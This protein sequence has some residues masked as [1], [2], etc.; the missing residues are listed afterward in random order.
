MPLLRYGSPEQKQ[1]Y[2]P[3]LADGS[4][5]GA[6]AGTEPEAGSDIFAMS[7]TATKREGGYVLDGK[8]IFVTNGPIA[9][10]LIVYAT[11]DRSLG[12]TGVTAFLVERGTEGMRVGP[13]MESMGLRAAPMAEISFDDCFIP[14]SHRLGREGRG[15]QVFAYAMEWE[16]G[17]GLAAP[18]G[19]MRRLLDA[20][21]RRARSR[22]Q[23]GS[24]IGK[25]QSVSHTIVD[26]RM[27]LDLSRM[28]LYR[29][30]ALKDRDAHVPAEMEAAMTKLYVSEA[31][32][33]TCFDA[34]RIFGGHGYLTEN[35]IE[36]DLRDAVASVLYSGTSH[37]QRN[38]IAAALGL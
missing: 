9:N 10:L 14:A 4:I 30:A 2:L 12:A 37:I 5:I 36:K 35:G 34:L 28:L 32:V 26:M 16:R 31:Y 17:C 23:F 1:K 27:R 33:Q 29:F 11:I 15:A 13:P 18:I 25:Y 24:A 7:T 3:S 20:S 21:I 38:I 22:K 8:K 19:V 6:S